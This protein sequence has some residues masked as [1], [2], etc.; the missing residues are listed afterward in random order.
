M[1]KTYK[2]VNTFFLTFT[3]LLDGYENA[4]RLCDLYYV[5]SPELELEE[6][7]GK[8]DVLFSSIIGDNDYLRREDKNFGLFDC[9]FIS[10]TSLLDMKA[11]KKTTVLE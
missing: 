7:N 10:S 5:N 8:L 9:R 1:H 11:E 3:F 4:M 2:L 6:L